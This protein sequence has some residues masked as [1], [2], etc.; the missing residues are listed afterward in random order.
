MG[1]LLASVSGFFGTIWWTA[2]IASVSFCAGIAMSSRV[3]SFLRCG[4]CDRG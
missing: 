3:K 1:Y 4:D 2:L